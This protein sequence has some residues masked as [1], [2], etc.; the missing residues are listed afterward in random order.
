MIAFKAPLDDI[1]YSLNAVAQAGGIDGYDA[2]LHSEIAQH[3]AAFA[4]G[5]L[6]PLNAICDR[7]GAQLRDGRVTLPDGFRAAYAKYRDQGWPAL[8]VPE[9]FGGQGMGAIA[10]GITSEIFSGANHAFEMTTGLAAGAV[11]TLIAFGTDSQKNEI[12]PKLASGDWLSTMALTEPGAGSDQ[13]QVLRDS[14]CER[15]AD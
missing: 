8:C 3:F 9:A 13:D 11:R 10:L 14:N 5:E 1:L 4:E 12:L 2:D 7:D 15:L 6:A